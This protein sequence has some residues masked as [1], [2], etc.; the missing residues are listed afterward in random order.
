[1]G[2]IS[3]I[4]VCSAVPFSARGAKRNVI[5]PSTKVEKTFSKGKRERERERETSSP[6]CR[7]KVLDGLPRCPIPSE[8]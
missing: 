1:M 3:L 5:A 8:S 6:R 4:N 2:L 7:H